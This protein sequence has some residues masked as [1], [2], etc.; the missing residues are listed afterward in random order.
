M[1]I[2]DRDRDAVSRAAA[3]I[4]APWPGDAALI[5][6]GAIRTVASLHPGAGAG[7]HRQWAVALRCLGEVCISIAK[8]EGRE[9]P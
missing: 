7:S 8:M 1:N 4:L 5:L 9:R 3:D 2:D 6:E